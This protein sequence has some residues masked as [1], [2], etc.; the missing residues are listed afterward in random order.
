MNTTA[1]SRSYAIIASAATGK[2]A[3]GRR[4]YGGGRGFVAT[5]AVRPASKAFAGRLA[6][7]ESREGGLRSGKLRS[8]RVAFAL[9]P[10]GHFSF[11]AP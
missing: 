3:H 2:A 11:A 8:E 1:R 7:A 4:G 10:R 9:Q 6:G 5:F